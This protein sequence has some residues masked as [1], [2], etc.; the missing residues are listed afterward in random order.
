MFS[1]SQDEPS[2]KTGAFAEIVGA[3]APTIIS[4]DMRVSGDMRTDG[5]V[6]ID[7]VV[8]GDIQ[9]STISI[10]KTAEVNGEVIAEKVKVF[11]RVNGRI[12]GKE[13][14]LM[15]TAEVNGDIIHESLEINRGAFIDGIVKRSVNEETK[16]V[17]GRPAGR[18]GH[19][20]QEGRGEGQRDVKAESGK[21]DLKT[22]LKATISGDAGSDKADAPAAK[23]AGAPPRGRRFQLAL[24]VR[25]ASAKRAGST[26]PPEQTMATVLPAA[27]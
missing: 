5:D 25:S 22:D 12:R 14:C 3:P 15:E 17:K 18:A 2:Q 6:Q 7:G 20:R 24:P 16:P 8:D 11:G 23:K 4:V 26:F 19:R 9:S 21:D 10:G 13:V 27:S 1:K